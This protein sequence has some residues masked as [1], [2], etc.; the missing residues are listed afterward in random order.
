MNDQEPH[1]VKIVD[2][3]LPLASVFNLYVQVAIIQ[4]AV[5]IVVGLVVV[6]V[7]YAAGVL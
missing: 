2:V 3:E 6:A 4:I 1:P 7:L 5:A